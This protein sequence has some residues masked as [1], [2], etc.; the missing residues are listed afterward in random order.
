VRPGRATAQSAVW[1]IG[2]G[3][4]LRARLARTRG[5]DSPLDFANLMKIEELAKGLSWIGVP[6][7]KVQSS[8]RKRVATRLERVSLR[9]GWNVQ[10]RVSLF[11]AKVGRV[12]DHKTTTPVVPDHHEFGK[13][14]SHTVQ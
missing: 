6:F 9:E 11:G 5:L 13:I 3:R 7:P 4:N 8:G 12:R 1:H 14:L 2:S 10:L